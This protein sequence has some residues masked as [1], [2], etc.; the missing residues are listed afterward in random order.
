[1]GRRSLS[2]LHVIQAATQKP[3]HPFHDGGAWWEGFERELSTSFVVQVGQG[4]SNLS[5]T[6]Q[7]LTADH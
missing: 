1:M 5:Q 4:E 6:F 3:R 2:D 7:V